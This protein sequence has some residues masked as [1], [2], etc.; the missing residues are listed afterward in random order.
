MIRRTTVAYAAAILVGSLGVSLGACSSSIDST[1]HASG[2]SGGGAPGT[3]GATAGTGG[4]SAAGAGGGTTAG[5]GGA[6]TTGAGGASA[7]SGGSWGEGGA[8]GVCSGSSPG[9]P[10]GAPCAPKDPSCFG[11]VA[12]CNPLGDYDGAAKFALRMAQLNLTAPDALAVGAIQG[13]IRSGVTPKNATCY[14]EGNGTFSWLLAFDQGAGTL[15]TGGAKPAAD[16][17]AGYSFVDADVNGY[18]GA[19]HIGSVKLAAPIQESCGVASD[20]G[21]VNLP[22]YL[23]SNA[24]D[25]FVLPLQHLRF[26]DV[27]L[28]PN[29][30]CIGSFNAGTLHPNDSCLPDTNAKQTSFTDGGSVE[31]AIALEDA[32]AVAIDAL[33]QSLC[34]LLSE[35]P[36]TYGDGGSPNRCK[37]QNGAIVLQGDWCMATNQPATPDCHDGLRFAGTFAASAVKVK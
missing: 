26:T 33:G 28:S 34:V 3:G 17:V 29:H 6:S 12:Q 22:V 5:S 2:G 25:L 36:Q 13:I 27:V 10:A 19:I 1:S 32:D 16:P 9:Y 8:G 37:R 11:D 7:G 14:L 20:E 4:A 24:T 30:D 21:S 18:G 23:D 35:S 15:V 31:A